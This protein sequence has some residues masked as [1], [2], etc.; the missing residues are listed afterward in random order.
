VIY[1][2]SPADPNSG[3][4]GSAS[5]PPCSKSNSSQGVAPGTF[6]MN[7]NSTLNAGGSA[8]NAEIF[9][10]GDP[11]DDPP[12]NSVNLLN[13]GSSSFALVAPFSNVTVAPSNNSVFV[14]AIVG[15]TVTLGNKSH[16]TYEADTG[17]LQ[18]P[19]LGLYYRAYWAQCATKPSSP[20]DPTSGC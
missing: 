10:Y 18:N 14:G 13:N 6:T 9:V 16:F 12:T 7:Q 11:Q 8:L 15:Y 19:A 5:N 1:I 2:D 20:T 3:S 4:P 17:P